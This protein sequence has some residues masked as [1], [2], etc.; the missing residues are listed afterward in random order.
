MV[1]V[2]KQL[3][4]SAIKL[5]FPGLCQTVHFTRNGGVSSIGALAHASNAVIAVTSAPTIRDN[6]KLY[7]QVRVSDLD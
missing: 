4:A 7:S 3:T 5:Y 2:Q 1:K 6:K